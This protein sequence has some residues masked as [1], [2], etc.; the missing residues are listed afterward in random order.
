[1]FFLIRGE[2]GGMLKVRGAEKKWHHPAGQRDAH[3]S[4]GKEL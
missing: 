3:N 2:L 4:R 1:M